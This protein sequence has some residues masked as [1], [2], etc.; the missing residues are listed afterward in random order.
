[1]KR[2]A[3]KVTAPPPNAE[4]KKVVEESVTGPSGVGKLKRA[5]PQQQQQQQQQ[6]E[7]E[8]QPQSQPQQ[9]Q[10]QPEQEDAIPS[11]NFREMLHLK[12]HTRAISSVKFSPQGELVASASADKTVKVLCLFS[13]LAALH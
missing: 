12:G 4:A 11:P 5:R 10:Q 13:C 8:Q 1:M 7:E 2:K 3:A 6:Q 9:P